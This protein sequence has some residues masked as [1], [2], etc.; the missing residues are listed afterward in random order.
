[1]TLLIMVR[2]MPVFF[3][4]ADWPP[5]RS[6]SERNKQMTSLS[7]R[8][9]IY[10]HPPQL[11]ASFIEALKDLDFI[12][13]TAPVRARVLQYPRGDT[14][15]DAKKSGVFAQRYLTPS[16]RATQINFRYGLAAPLRFGNHCAPKVKS[17]NWFSVAHLLKGLRP[18]PPRHPVGALSIS[19]RL[20]W[21]PLSICPLVCRFLRR[22]NADAIHVLGSRRPRSA[23][24]RNRGVWG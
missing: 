1:M 8:K 5:A 24:A 2:L 3:A 12:K 17:R 16:R 23:K 10:S 11:A 9:R 20:S 7:S 4:H 13:K 14:L 22:R 19:G 18:R 6:T 15:P 21:R